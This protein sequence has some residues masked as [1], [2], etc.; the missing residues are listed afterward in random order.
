M[1]PAADSPAAPIEVLER[2][3]RDAER[4]GDFARVC[5]IAEDAAENARRVGDDALLARAQCWMAQSHLYRGALRECLLFAAQAEGLARG[6]GDDLTVV[7]VYSLIGNCE[8]QL[9]QYAAAKETLE[10]GIALADPH[11]FAVQAATMRGTLGSVLG[12]MGRFDEGEAAFN[13]SIAELEAA[14]DGTRRLRVYGNLAGLLRRRAE[15]ARANGDEAL[16]KS[17]FAKAIDVARGAYAVA[18]GSNDSGQ[19]PYSLG[20][21]GAL[22]HR[23]GDLEA[24]ESCLRQSLAIGEALANRRLIALGALDLARVLRDRSQPDEALAMLAKAREAALA[25]NLALQLAECWAE[26]AA[27][28]E[29]R[30]DF[31]AALDAHRQFHAAEVERLAADRARAEQSRSA[32]DEIRRLRR[33]A[34]LLGLK[35]AAAEQQAR[36]D[37]LTGLFNRAGFDVEALPLLDRSAT[38]PQALTMAWIDVDRFKLVNDRFG[39]PIGDVVLATV[40]RM[41]REHLRAGDLA[42][43]LGG[44]EFAVIIRDADRDAGV[45]SVA[46]LHDAVRAYPWQEIAVGLA[47]TVSIGCAQLR[48]GEPLDQLARRADAAMYAAKRSGRDKIGEG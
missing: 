19:L 21:L 9:A 35:A 23:V 4:A 16:S 13:T 44:D 32:L 7:R 18:R 48:P 3:C 11:G 22:Y 29:E 46:R 41:L 28:Q 39:H 40:G 36:L 33:E 47:V 1:T 30:G 37:P 17:T 10:A 26:E 2:A 25:G 20:M 6:I 45:R 31:R 15:H 43:R 34:E 42:A 27:V 8:F 24:A 38:E 12:A 5:A 14:G